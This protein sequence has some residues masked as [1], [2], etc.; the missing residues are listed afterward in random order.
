MSFEN[1]VKKALGKKQLAK[2]EEIYDNGFTYE[3]V[4]K[5]PFANMQYGGETI[6]VYDYGSWEDESF[7]D[8]VDNACYWVE[9]AEDVGKA[10]WAKLTGEA[11]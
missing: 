8:C 4:L 9:C 3:V 6:W 11:A 2:V 7:E 10:E 5:A 1:A